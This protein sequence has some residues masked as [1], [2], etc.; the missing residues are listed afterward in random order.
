MDGVFSRANAELNDPNSPYYLGR[1]S[2][3]EQIN[4]Y[5]RGEYRT[6]YFGPSASRYLSSL[7]R[8]AF[9]LQK[10]KDREN[11]ERI[12]TFFG[13]GI[14]AITAWCLRGKIPFIGKFLKKAKA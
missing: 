6:N 13:V 4:S 3:I 5:L 9:M 7:D 12:L 10:A 14:A 1:P 11:N 2:S 8:D